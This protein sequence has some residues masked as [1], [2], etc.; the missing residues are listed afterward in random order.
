MIVLASVSVFSDFE[1]SALEPA[2]AL[3]SQLTQKVKISAAR[4][5]FKLVKEYK[6]K[7]LDH[8]SL[9][10]HDEAF[11]AAYRRHQPGVY[12]R[13]S[14]VGQAEAVLGHNPLDVHIGET[15]ELLG[16][17]KQGQNFGLT[18]EDSISDT[19]EYALNIVVVE[20]NGVLSG[21]LLPNFPDYPKLDM[22]INGTPRMR[23]R[24]I[25]ADSQIQFSMQR[26]LYQTIDQIEFDVNQYLSTK[27]KK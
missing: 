3:F 21:Q 24:N 8:M 19:L 27:I 1:K 14:S 5:I 20:A 23:P 4:K 17:L 13:V 16:E 22:I 6:G 25:L 11:F 7:I 9:T 2:A 18:D 12:S 26:S 15:K 10:D